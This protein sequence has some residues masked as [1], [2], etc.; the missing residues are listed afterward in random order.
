MSAPQATMRE[1]FESRD[2]DFIRD[3]LPI[4][5]LAASFWYRAEVRGPAK[6]PM[7]QCFWW[8]ITRG[9]T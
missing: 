8:G 2:V 5:W 6:I 4:L 9:E 7:G 1:D 3:F